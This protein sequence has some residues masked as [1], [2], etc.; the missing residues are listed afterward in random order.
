MWRGG[1]KKEIACWRRGCDREGKKLSALKRSWERSR[2]GN[3]SIQQFGA[4]PKD[5]FGE[6]RRKKEGNENLCVQRASILKG[7][8]LFE[9]RIENE[10]EGGKGVWLAPTRCLLWE[11]KK[12]MRLEKIKFNFWSNWREDK[13]VILSS[14]DAV[15]PR[16]FWW[17]WWWTRSNQIPLTWSKIKT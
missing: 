15:V 4:F 10:W 3:E 11:G 9:L 6:E 14:V 2:G 8:L 7:F 13:M 17:C 5:C 16:C 12:K 1:V